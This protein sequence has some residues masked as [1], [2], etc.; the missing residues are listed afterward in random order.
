MSFVWVQV[1]LVVIGGVGELCHG[2]G[3]L[4][5]Y[6]PIYIKCVCITGTKVFISSTGDRCSSILLAGIAI[7]SV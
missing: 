4:L 2:M 7:T 5:N 3:D 6:H 1:P